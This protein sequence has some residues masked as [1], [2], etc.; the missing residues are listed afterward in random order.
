MLNFRRLYES[1]KE[2]LEHNIVKEI[3]TEIISIGKVDFSEE[4]SFKTSDGSQI[5][6]VEIGDEG[7]FILRKDEKKIEIAEDDEVFLKLI[8]DP[9]SLICLAEAVEKQLKN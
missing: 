2:L 3:A 5:I 4:N 7:M 8:E 6:G 1:S 9:Y